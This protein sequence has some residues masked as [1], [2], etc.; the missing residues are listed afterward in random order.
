MGIKIIKISTATPQ[1]TSCWLCCENTISSCRRNIDLPVCLG[2]SWRLLPITGIQ[3]RLVWFKNRS[4]RKYQS[5]WLILGYK[6]IIIHEYSDVIVMKFIIWVRCSRSYRTRLC[7]NP[8]NNRWDSIKIS[9]SLKGV[10]RFLWH[11]IAFSPF[12]ARPTFLFWEFVFGASKFVG[13]YLYQHKVW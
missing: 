13:K 7:K 10:S 5:R 11:V 12:I 3:D 2:A 8:Q 4:T 9:Q 1:K 6:L